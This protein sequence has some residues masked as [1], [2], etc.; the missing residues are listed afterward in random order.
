METGRWLGK[1]EGGE[2]RDVR[3]W[4]GEGGEGG[5]GADTRYGSVNIPGGRGN[6]PPPLPAPLCSCSPSLPSPGSLAYFLS[7]L[8]PSLPSSLFFSVLFIHDS[9]RRPVGQRGRKGRGERVYKIPVCGEEGGR[10]EG[11]KDVAL[12][13]F[14]L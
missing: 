13:L 9:I 12:F 4:V 5:G 10:G 1:G 8:S 14:C 2:K 6:S 7:L 3:W 11:V